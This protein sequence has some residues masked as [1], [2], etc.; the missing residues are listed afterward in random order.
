MRL[1][2]VPDRGPCAPYPDGLGLSLGGPAA[3]SASDYATSLSQMSFCELLATVQ[4]LERKG[5][6]PDSFIDSLREY[7]VVASD[8]DFATGGAS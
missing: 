1:E 7:V 3:L 4:L 2:H 5:R 8:F 6:V